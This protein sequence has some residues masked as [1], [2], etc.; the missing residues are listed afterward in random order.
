MKEVVTMWKNTRMIILVALS[1]AIYAAFLIVFKGGIPIVPGITEVRPA[2]VFPPVFGLLFGPAGA[3]GAAI[4]NLIGDLFG[5]TL[6]I[7]SIFGFFGNFFLGFIP[8][9]MWGATF[10][11]V[12]KNDMSQNTN[13][14]KKVLAFEL[15]SLVAAAACG[16]IIAWYLDIAGMVPFAFLAITITVNN[17]AASVVLGPILLL[18]LYPRVKRW[19]LVWTDIMAKEDVAKGFA[20]NIGSILMIIGA[21][22]G[23]VAGVLVAIGV[24][25]QQLYGFTGEQG[26]VAVWLSVLPFLLMIIVASVML[27]GREQFVE[28]LED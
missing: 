11:L 12:P 13:S 16:I 17:F 23:L 18:L 21:I 10:G 14:F 3:W 4:G 26:Q 27:S 28:E 24:A 22:G 25:G 6:G 1:A 19:G 9:K 2:N 20:K 8:Y 7:G 5:G 15:V